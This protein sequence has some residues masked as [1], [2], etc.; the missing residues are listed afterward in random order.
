MVTVNPTPVLTSTLTPAA[1]CDNTTFNYTPTSSTTGATFAWT[2]AVVVGIANLIGSG[3]GNPSEVLDNTT[4]LPVNVTYVYTV[5]ANGCTN[6]TTFS[7]VVTVNPTPNA[8]ATLSTQTVC[9]GVAITTISL[10]G[11]VLGTTFNWT[12]NNTVNV[13]GIT[14]SGSGNISGTLSHILT[15]AQTVTFTITPTAN[16]CSGASITS[17]VIVNPLTYTSNPAPQTI[18][19]FTNAVFSVTATGTAPITYQWELSTDGG[20]I[21]SPL[22]N[23]GVYSG[24]FTN[25]LTLTS[26]PITMTGYKYRCVVTGGCSIA[27]SNAATLTVSAGPTTTTLIT[28]AASVRYMDNLTMTAQ[29]TPQFNG[30]PVT[31]SVEFFIG[32]TSYGTAPVVSIP[33]SVNGSVQAMMIKQ[34]TNLPAGYTVEAIFTSTNL[35]YLGTPVT[36]S[37][38][39]SSCPL[40]KKLLTVIPRTASPYTATGMYTGDGFAWTT[41]PSTSTATLTMVAAIKDNSSPTGDVRSAKVSF[42]FVNGTILTPIPSAQNLPVGLIDVTDGSVGTAS[43]IVQLNI[44]SLNSQSFQVAV[45]VTGAYTNN[46]YD[47]LSQTIVTVSKPVTGGFITGGSSVNNQNSSGY[48]KGATGLNTDYQFDIQYNSSGTNPKGKVNILVRS[49]YDNTGILDS[50]LHTYFIRTN[51]IAL[52]AIS[53]P[54][55]TGT[56]S[57]KANM[58]EQLA[59]GTVVSVESGATFQMV[60]FQNACNQQIAITYYRKAGGV[61]FSSRWNTITAKTDLQAVTPGSKVYVFGGGNCSVAPVIPASRTASPTQITS[62]PIVPIKDRFDV[63]VIGNPTTT[64]FKL[65]LESNDINKE[66]TVNVVDVNGRRVELKQNLHAGQVV[67]IGKQFRTGIYFAEVSQGIYH[68]VVKLVK[69]N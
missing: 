11:D 25:T 16:S 17:D 50:K 64:S 31:G 6:A 57:A 54:L 26:V 44:G 24:A 7:V 13:T 1:I 14:N 23:V 12:R 18:I 51:A 21:F 41:G 49:Y 59:D 43:A 8:V 39:V 9:S 4:A 37:C 40:N 10:S 35:N 30:S 63:K 68:K 33:G 19:A 29:I 15:T 67:E 69:V 34:V 65:K 42:Y 66:I 36:G 62:V 20:T 45:K 56:F 3:S 48:I 2:R 61:W 58:E 46:P 32:T 55:A 27:T 28:S 38:T 60:A 52:L 53:N 22:S 47:A 5:S